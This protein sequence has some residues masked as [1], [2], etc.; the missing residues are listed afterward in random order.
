[1]FHLFAVSWR[2]VCRHIAVG[3]R[4]VC[5]PVS[6]GSCDS[7]VSVP[8]SLFVILPGLFTSLWYGFLLGA[9]AYM[10][11]KDQRAAP[12]F[13]IYAAIMFGLGVYR[14]EV[15]MLVCVVAGLALF[16]FARF[17]HLSTLLS[18]RWLQFLGTIS[19]SL[20]LIHNPITGATFR[21]GYRLTERTMATEALWWAVS[22]L[23][24][25]GAAAVMWWAIE[26][27]SLWLSKI[28]TLRLIEE[29]RGSLAA[30]V[31]QPIR[32]VVSRHR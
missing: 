5:E 32:V 10:S 22:V 18:W 9:G 31:Q 27:P 23:A 21:I 15:F 8:L 2:D 24:C 1:M 30:D 25:V 14:L 26:R 19:Y 12:W 7:A 11:W 17:G 4:V 29:T 16:T 20:Y 13:L 3:V 28:L 6:L